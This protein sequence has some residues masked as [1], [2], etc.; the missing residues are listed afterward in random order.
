MF[1][2]FILTRFNIK[3]DGIASYD[4]NKMPVQT[5]E[6]LERRF[7]LFEKYCLPSIIKQSCKNF[8]WFVL[9]SSDTPE[10]FVKKIKDYEMQFPLFRPLF[11]ETGSH[12]CIKKTINNVLTSYINTE[13]QYVITSRI[14]NDDAFHS[15]MIL[16]VQR[17][18]NWQDNIFVSFTYGRQYDIERNVLARMYCRKNH[19]VSRIEKISNEVDTVITHDHTL[20]DE[21]GEVIYINNKKKP[22]W[23]EIVHDGNLENRLYPD[24]IPLFRGKILESFQLME[25]ISRVNTLALVFNYLKL[26]ALLLRRDLLRK[27]GIYDFMK[28]KI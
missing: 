2:H 1:K 18:F 24:S 5:E 3:Y 25:K 13:D 19:F 9:F 12:D 20:I 16:E 27:L 17:L 6:W 4:K 11:L 7:L 26:K 10:Q 8:I 21:V 23:L 14:D 28:E 22:M 15:D